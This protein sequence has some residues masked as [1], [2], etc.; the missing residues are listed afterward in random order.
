VS[1]PSQFVLEIRG[2]LAKRFGIQSGDAVSFEGI[3]EGVKE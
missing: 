3:S 2:G 1:A